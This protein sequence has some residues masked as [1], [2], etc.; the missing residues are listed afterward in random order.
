MGYSMNSLSLGQGHVFHKRHGHATNQFQY[1]TF[2][3][4]INTS[5]ETELQKLFKNRAWR[6][7]SLSKSDY[8]TRQSTNESLGLIAKNFLKE[9]CHYEA[10]DV[11]LHTL[12]AMFGYVFNPISFWLCQKNGKLDAVLCEVSNTFG[13]HHFYWIAPGRVDLAAGEWATAEK[14]FHVSPFFPVEGFYKFRFKIHENAANID[15]LY[16][17]KNGDLV[18]TTSVHGKLTPLKDLSPWRLLF[19]Y[20]WLTPLVLLRIHYQAVRLWLKKARFYSKPEPPR[21][22]IT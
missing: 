8:L 16:H 19:K 15:I 4:Y 11:W 7:F 1:P 17:N 6:I 12:P 14:L 2:F 21:E 3:L 20:G 22:E 13:E 18:L 5:S 9:R 10:E